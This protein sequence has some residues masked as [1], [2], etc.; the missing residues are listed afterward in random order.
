MNRKEA[1]LTQG[2][3]VVFTEQNPKCSY[4]G[5]L[6]HIETPKKT[7]FGLEKLSYKAFM[8]FTMPMT[9]SLFITVVEKKLT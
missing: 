3:T 1:H 7:K 6:Q 2:K 4:Y 5:V 8:K 9:S